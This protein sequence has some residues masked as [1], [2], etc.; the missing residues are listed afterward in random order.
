[1]FSA[2]PK[3]QVALRIKTLCHERVASV[4]PEAKNLAQSRLPDVDRTC[5]ECDHG[6]YD[7]SN[8][9]C[10]GCGPNSDDF[11]MDWNHHECTDIY[12]SEHSREGTE[13]GEEQA[14]WQS[15][16]LLEE[17]DACDS[18]GEYHPASR[19]VNVS[20]FSSRPHLTQ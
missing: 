13:E 2:P 12:D 17:E 15:E 8:K 19:Q 5:I 20:S 18:E 14:E 4:L 10:D 3:Y 7:D 9:W 16:G 6:S 1:M 11:E